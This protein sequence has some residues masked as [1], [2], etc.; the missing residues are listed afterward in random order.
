MAHFGPPGTSQKGNFQSNLITLVQGSITHVPCDESVCS[1]SM[2][3][4][5]NN[6]YMRWTSVT[7]PCD[8]GVS[9]A[10]QPDTRQPASRPGRHH[11]HM[12]GYL[13]TKHEFKE[14]VKIIWRSLMMSQELKNIILSITHFQSSMSS[15]MWAV[16]KSQ[17]YWNSVHM[18]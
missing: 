13:Q 1:S 18:W 10:R 8:V 12:H 6:D 3:A 9:I 7:N 17:S 14:R 2:Q 4:Q 5:Y 15:H 11:S 16:I